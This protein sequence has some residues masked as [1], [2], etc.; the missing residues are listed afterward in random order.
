[1]RCIFGRF[2]RGPKISALTLPLLPCPRPP[3]G[4]AECPESCP[5]VAMAMAKLHGIV[6]IYLVSCKRYLRQRVSGCAAPVGVSG[7][8][9]PFQRHETD[10]GQAE[11]TIVIVGVCT[12]V[13]MGQ[14]MRLWVLLRVEFVSSSYVVGRRKEGAHK[15]LADALS[16]LQAS[17]SSTLLRCLNISSACR[18]ARSMR[19]Q[20]V[21]VFRVQQATNPR[22]NH[23]VYRK[24]LSDEQH[25]PIPHEPANDPTT[26]MR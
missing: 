23:M 9:L 26:R 19:I 16:N 24:Y 4:S 13:A 7:R 21:K 18:Q 2:I 10:T 12:G 8:L 17:G 3:H 6:C 15:L 22:R 1:M 11:T 25:L 14:M 5:V 20:I